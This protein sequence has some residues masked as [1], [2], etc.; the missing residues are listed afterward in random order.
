MGHVHEGKQHH[1]RQTSST[2]ADTKACSASALAQTPM[3]VHARFSA[4]AL[5]IV[6]HKHKSR[7]IK[8]M[9]TNT[10]AGST[11]ASVQGSKMLGLSRALIQTR[12]NF[13]TG[14]SNTGMAGSMVAADIGG[15]TL[16]QKRQG[17]SIPQCL[18]KEKKQSNWLDQGA[19]SKPIMLG[20]RHTTN[21][22]QGCAYQGHTEDQKQENLCHEE[23][24]RA[25]S[26]SSKASH[27]DNTLHA[28]HL[29]CYFALEKTGKNEA[30][31]QASKK[32]LQSNRLTASLKNEATHVH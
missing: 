31:L 20:R 9:Y 2:D 11:N 19:D 5:I 13:N 29:P 3:Q 27:W 22:S 1:G 26:D 23:R 12:T 18:P 28:Q 16:S 15:H 21:G 10:E 14:N 8:C 17:T 24:R 30:T 4:C 32:G 6:K 25:K 7:V